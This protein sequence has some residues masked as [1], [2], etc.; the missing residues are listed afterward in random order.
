MWHA[1]T[2]R[3]SFIETGSRTKFR[4]LE[5]GCAGWGCLGPNVSSCES[6]TS[7]HLTFSSVTCLTCSQLVNS[8]FH[9][10]WLIFISIMQQAGGLMKHRGRAETCDWQR[11]REW[12]GMDVAMRGAEENDRMVDHRTTIMKGKKL[13]CWHKAG[14]RSSS[15]PTDTR[16]RCLSFCRCWRL[17]SAD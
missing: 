11:G 1:T 4:Q 10:L 3:D 12:G 5:G 9:F 2:T 14:K 16:C 6:A 15:G 8:T 13:M 7:P 17:R